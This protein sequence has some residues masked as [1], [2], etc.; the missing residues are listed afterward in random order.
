MLA[1]IYPMWMI[2]MTPESLATQ[3]TD[4]VGAWRIT[5]HCLHKQDLSGLSDF[6]EPHSDPIPVRWPSARRE[7]AGCRLLWTRTASSTGLKA[8]NHQ[9]EPPTPGTLDALRA[10][11]NR[12]V[13]AGTSGERKRAI[14]ALVHEVKITEHGMIPVFKNPK[15]RERPH[16]AQRRRHRRHERRPCRDWPE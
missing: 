9:P 16:V 7:V 14:E 4:R 12:L 6:T 1:T 8:L 13:A 3:D 5:R 10:C 2:A 15:R 11:L